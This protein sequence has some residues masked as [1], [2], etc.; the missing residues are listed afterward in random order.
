MWENVYLR[1][2]PVHDLS[3][4]LEGNVASDGHYFANQQWQFIEDEQRTLAGSVVDKLPDAVPLSKYTRVTVSQWPENDAPVFPPQF[5]KNR[6]TNVFPQSLSPGNSVPIISI[7][8]Q[9]SIVSSERPSDDAI[10]AMIN[11]STPIIR[12][13]LQ[14]V[15]PVCTPGTKIAAPGLTWPREYLSAIG[16]A[17]YERGVDIEMVLC[18]PRSV[19]GGRLDI[20]KAI[21]ATPYGNGWTC[22]DVAAEIIKSIQQQYKNVD[23]SRLRAMV[24]DNL[25]ICYIRHNK[26]SMYKD[27]NT[28]GLHSKHWIVDD[29]C[30]YVGSQNLYDCDLAEW[31]VV[32]D[33]EAEVTNIMNTYFVPMWRNSYIPGQDVDVDQVMDA[34]DVDREGNENDEE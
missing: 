14:D 31:G 29:K 34:L 28:I 2:N 17:I 13:V 16:K 24:K 30:C 18:N 4:Q 23:D 15:G 6:V 19:P 33:D 27:G 1:S 11:S 3:I 22:V 10:L 8:C 9:G 32:I 25:R 12:F 7:G 21:I 26:S 5:N 20:K